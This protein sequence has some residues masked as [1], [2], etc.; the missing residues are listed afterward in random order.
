MLFRVVCTIHKYKYEPGLELVCLFRSKQKSWWFDVS[1]IYDLT[2]GVIWKK[3]LLFFVPIVVGTLFQQLYNAVDAVIVG[4]WVSTQALAAVGGSASQVSTLFIGFFVAVTGGASAVIAQ[5]VGARDGEN[6]SK[7]VHA[8]MTFFILAGVVM[9]VCII[10]AVPTILRWMQTPEDTMEESILYLR[11]YFGGSVFLM[12]FN[13]GSS[14]LRAVGDSRRPLYYLV[15]CCGLNIVLDLV[16]VIVLN[17][18]IAGAAW[19]T[20]ASEGLCAFLVMFQLCRTSEVYRVNLSQLRI[21]GQVMKKMLRVGIPAGLQASMYNIANLIIQVAINTLGTAVVAGWSLAMK[22]DG[23]Y[24]A[25]S[26][27][28]S[29][30]V[31]NFVGQNFGAGKLDR[32]KKTFKVAMLIFL[33]VTVVM[34][35]ALLSIGKFG[36]PILNGDPEVQAAAWTVL[37][38]LVPFYFVWTLVEVTSGVLRGC[39]DAFFPVVITC[40]CICVVRMV[41]L[42]TAFRLH[43]GVTTLGMIYPISWGLTAVCLTTY[44]IR[45]N[46]LNR[47]LPGGNS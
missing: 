9:T 42:A 19:A 20:V 1:K 8:S 31:M 18:G 39:G 2:E 24:A 25:I 30:A 34:E 6:V 23:I 44:Y 13:M 10:P 29:L 37:L 21:H 12:I 22:L 36:M 33:V 7:A 15:I 11:I 38:C 4:K 35:A 27:A 5:L 40:V 3:L 17:M 45:G 47:V 43:P 46:W 14:I 26:G 28:L 32:V 16:C 41:W